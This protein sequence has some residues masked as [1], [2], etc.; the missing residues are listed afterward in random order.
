MPRRKKVQTEV[1]EDTA[2]KKRPTTQPVK[3]SP[4]KPADD[5]PSRWDK[6]EG[7][8]G[9]VVRHKMEDQEKS[10]EMGRLISQ[11][12]A[13]RLYVGVDGN[14]TYFYFEIFKE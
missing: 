1:I 9:K 10:V 14:F 5:K 6:I 4:I 13:K 7:V 12:K 3:K 11:G 8:K 2:P